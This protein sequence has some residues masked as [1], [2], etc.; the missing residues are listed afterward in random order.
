[1][2]EDLRWLGLNWDNAQLVFQSKR[3]DIYNAIIADLM[4]RQLAYKA[5]ETPQELDAQ[6]RLA[7]R[8]R[9]PYIY[10]RP[11]LTDEQIPQI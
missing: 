8:A 2:L 5:F 4:S 6:R 10:K 11:N 9:R 7:E 1:L 3:L